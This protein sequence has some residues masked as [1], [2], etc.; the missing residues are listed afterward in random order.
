MFSACAAD[1]K[2]FGHLRGAYQKIQGTKP[3]SL[4]YGLNDSPV[5]LL[6]WIL[7]LLGCKSPIRAAE[8]ECLSYKNQMDI[9][10]ALGDLQW[11]NL[12]NK[13]K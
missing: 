13:G 11:H 2:A 7:E 3:Q 6:A 10:E 4:G 9:T 5:G 8:S 1:V 12:S